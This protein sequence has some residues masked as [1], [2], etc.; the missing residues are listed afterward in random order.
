MDVGCW[1]LGLAALNDIVI[2]LGCAKFLT[3]PLWVVSNTLLI[4]LLRQ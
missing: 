4:L 2:M 1:T 3:L